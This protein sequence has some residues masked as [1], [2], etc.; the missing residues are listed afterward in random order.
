MNYFFPGLGDFPDL[1]DHSVLFKVRS[2]DPAAG[3]VMVFITHH[4]PTYDGP[5]MIGAFDHGGDGLPDWSESASYSLLGYASLWHPDRGHFV[6]S[7]VVA[8]VLPDVRPITVVEIEYLAAKREE[9]R[10]LWRV[11]NPEADVRDLV[12]RIGAAI[13]DEHENGQ[14][15]R[16][17]TEALEF[18]YTIDYATAPIE[19]VRAVLDHHVPNYDPSD[20]QLQVDHVIADAASEYFE[21]SW[22]PAQL[23]EPAETP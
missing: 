18:D 3:H 20:W 10:Q 8:S 22:Q 7:P 1:G 17:P 14:P 11:A 2:V 19:T 12:A 9:A 16:Y 23:K 5:R 15:D 13:A 4:P 6:D 21:Y